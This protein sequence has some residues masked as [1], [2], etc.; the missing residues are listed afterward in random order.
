[1][2]ILRRSRILNPIVSR[3]PRAALM[4]AWG[5]GMGLGLGLGLA[6]QGFAATTP[7]ATADA[8]PAAA[9]AAA[10]ISS[11]HLVILYRKE[12]ADAPNRLD[13]TVQAVT[14]ALQQE[15]LK[16]QYQIIEPS[17]D[18]YRAMDQGPGVIVTFAPDAGMTLVY[19][20][21]ANL[22]PQP[23]TNV[24]IAE[25]RIAARVFVGSN[26]LAAEQGRGQI[27]TR[28]DP[29]LRDYGE[30]RG[31][32]IA[33]QRASLEL[34]GNVDTRL[35]SLT[36]EQIANLTADDSTTATSFVVVNPPGSGA[37]P[38]A[39]ATLPSSP[40]A[41]PGS[42]PTAALPGATASPAPGP[43]PAP[44]S[45]SAPASASAKGKR[46]LLSVGVGNYSRIQGVPGAGTH[47]H[48]LPGTGTDV[49]NVR[50]SL[51][52]FGFED[53]TTTQL[54]DE[55]A[56]TAAVRSALA[57][58]TASV[59]RDDVAVLYVTG[60]G[61][62]E[63]FGKAGVTMPVFFDTNLDAPPGNSLN[64]AELVTLFSRVPARQ[65]VMLIDT[66]HSGGAVTNMTTV[67][68]SSRAVVVTHSGGSPD[69]ARVMRA[70]KDVRGDIAVMSAARTDETAVDLGAERGGLFT[71]NLVKALDQTQGLAPMED[72]YKNYVWTAVTKYCRA[73]GAAACQQSPVLGYGGAGNKIRL[74]P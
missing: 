50:K 55:A 38:G 54:F 59:G 63:N 39:A 71:S 49:K 15:F 41:A 9:P 6:P 62:E 30:R 64:F 31:Y 26:L 47:E 24:G 5:A 43:A 3:F 21:Y 44:G 57:R 1:M 33:A 53:A 67:A 65:L 72:V 45:G 35:Q 17:P 42:G 4:L 46:W 56:T 11:K 29:A 74:A 51:K 69:V 28:T 66:C 16:R 20:V 22:R 70:A 68:V 34:A 18:T 60:H 48:D 73:A 14:L 37:E 52:P 2:C 23:G 32:E 10:G 36:P 40:A 8:T 13:P 58:L 19:S 12:T 61:V 7:A 25:V 27:Q